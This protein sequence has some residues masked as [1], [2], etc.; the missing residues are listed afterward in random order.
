MN[1]YNPHKIEKKWQEVWEKEKTFAFDE[2]SKKK[3]L[4]ILD[5][6]PYPS[7][8][9]LH[10]GHPE[11]YTA[12]DI[13]SRYQR[14]KGYNVI[15][16]MGWDAFGL[17]AEN[18][19]IKTKVHPAETTKK[20]IDNF[21][22]QIKSL[23]FSYDWSREI[24]TAHPEY[25][26]WTQWLFLYLYKKD[27]AYQK[28]APVNWCPSCQTVLANEQVVAGACERCGSEVEQKNLTQWFFKTTDYTERLLGD[29][30]DIDWPEGIKSS[31]RNWIGKSEGAMLEFKI[32][33][34]ELSIKTF[35][36]RPDTLFGATYM[37]LAPENGLVNKLDIENRKEVDDYIKKT[38][39]KTELE[40]ITEA[41]EKT[42]IELKGVKAVNPANRKEIPI[43]V[44]DYV[45]AS[46]GT[47]AIMAVP[48]HDKRDY[49]FAKKFKISIPQVIEGGDPASPGASQGGLPYIGEGK[50]VNSGKF[51]GLSSQEAK[52]KI[53]EFVKGKKQIQYKLRDWLISRQRYWG[54][55]IPII[56]CDK[57][58]AQ[59]VPE[60]DLPVV[61]PTDVD[62]KPKGE[63]PLASSKE[64]HNVKC[65]KCSGSARRE[66]DTLDTFVDSSWYY[67][68]YLDPRNE[69]EIFDKKKVVELMPIDLYVG[70]AEHAVLHLLYS[71]FITKALKDG[72]Y[73][74]LSEPFSKLRNQGM[75]LGPDGQRMSKSKGNV[76]NPDDVVKEFG[77]DAFRMY[78]MFMGP[79]EDDI[80]WNTNSIMGVFRFLTRV[81]NFHLEP[82][83]PS[84]EGSKELQHLTHKT[85]KKVEEDINGFNFNTAISALMIL[86]KSIEK[87]KD[88]SAFRTF[89]LLLYPFAPHISSELWEKLKYSAQ[90]GSASGGGHIWEEPWPKVEKK[91]LA[92]KEIELIVQVNGK[93][94]DTITLSTGLSKKE[95]EETAKKSENVIKYIKDKKVKK[96]IVV[97]DRL[98]NFVTG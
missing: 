58:G 84:E 62:F 20:S 51:N 93:L 14:M 36:T 74:S 88:S 5:M 44:A 42:G 82:A 41:K 26:R 52:N 59:P 73:V 10:V 47:G 8:E 83:G 67:F 85:I 71:R 43:F 98:V 30:E 48:A 32:K 80:A 63:S 65:P 2:D 4:Y 12:T 95:L 53:T 91:Y 49:E 66:S 24:S 81:W 9:G 22:R 50:L 55:P 16:P 27:L 40:R 46:Y 75:V 87:E 31:Q 78:E 96:V 7:G 25:Y 86:L 45:L 92:K 70:G 13:I 60:K 38:S 69:K 97:P 28:E 15:H 6:L 37:V 29:L 19:A 18:Y 1:K 54:P 34:Q 56:Y 89:L 79:F 76:I 57:C 33:D 23:G 17:P 35:T 94:R 3:K 11:G 64:F 68:R 21:R 77:A 39:K 90:G 72:G 61:L